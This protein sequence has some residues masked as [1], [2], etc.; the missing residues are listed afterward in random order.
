MQKRF[1][2]LKKLQD[3]LAR[4]TEIETRLVES[5]ARLERALS[6]ASGALSKALEYKQQE[7]ERHIPGASRVIAPAE[8]ADTGEKGLA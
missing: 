8:D 6:S 2:Q 7:L 3:L 5:G 4:K 1:N